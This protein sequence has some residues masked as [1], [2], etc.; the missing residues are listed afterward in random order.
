MRIPSN[1]PIPE[2]VYL[3]IDD[4]LFVFMPGITRDLWVQPGIENLTRR[5]R[6]C[7]FQLDFECLCRCAHS[8]FFSFFFFWSLKYCSNSSR[9]SFQN[10]S[11]SCTHPA[12]AWSGSPRNEMRTSRPCFLRSMS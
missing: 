1:E 12:T 11:Y 9:R 5:S 4:Q 3:R 2:P 10:R 7:P 8:F 6:N